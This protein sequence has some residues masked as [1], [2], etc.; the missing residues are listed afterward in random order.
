[1]SAR[2]SSSNYARADPLSEDAAHRSYENFVPTYPHCLYQGGDLPSQGLSNLRRQEFEEAGFTHHHWI[3]YVPVTLFRIRP[4]IFCD[5]LPRCPWQHEDTNE[6][7][8]YPH[9][10]ATPTTIVDGPGRRTIRRYTRNRRCKRWTTGKQISPLGDVES[11][12]LARSP[13]VSINYLFIY[14]YFKFCLAS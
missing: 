11:S 7:P 3:L 2:V 10:H 1:M 13:K 12:S 6:H 14:F 8:G 5:I 9:Q 4:S